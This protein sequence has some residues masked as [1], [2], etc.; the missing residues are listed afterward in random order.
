M[1]QVLIIIVNSIYMLHE[2]NEME[3]MTIDK[4]K[5]V[6]VIILKITCK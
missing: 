3:N 4:K 6:I 2:Y 1:F 5:I